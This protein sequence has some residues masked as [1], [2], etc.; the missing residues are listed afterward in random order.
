[1]LQKGTLS[2]AF[3]IYWEDMNRCRAGKA[4]WCLL[5]VTVCLPD[6]CAALQSRTANRA[7]ADAG[8]WAAL[9]GC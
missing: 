1:M 5:H 3:T 8:R 6:I 9:R 2:S 4:Y 7:A